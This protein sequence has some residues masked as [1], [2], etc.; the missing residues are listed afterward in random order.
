MPMP[1]S[2]R[3]ILTTPLPRKER[4]VSS[5][6]VWLVGLFSFQNVYAVQSLLPSWM[7]DFHASAADVG[8]TVGATV[9]G[10]ALLSPFIGMLSDAVGRKRIIVAALLALSLPTALIASAHSLDAVVWLR[11]AQGLAIPGVSVVMM[12]YIGEEFRHQNVGRMM[13]AFVSGSVTGGFLGRLLPGH[14]S[15]WADWRTAFV[16]L[17][18]I[19]VL[20]AM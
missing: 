11:F 5:P 17:G 9:L 19:N 2:A 8:S 15:E 3:I 20:G 6:L 16:V 10:I 14:I 18:L 7:R 4:I 1:D 13:A 12:A